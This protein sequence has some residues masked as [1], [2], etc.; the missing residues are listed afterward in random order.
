MDGAHLP[1]MDVG[2]NPYT[3]RHLRG[4]ARTA[5]EIGLTMLAADDHLLFAVP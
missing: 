1:L 5:V 4:F 3:P 2:G